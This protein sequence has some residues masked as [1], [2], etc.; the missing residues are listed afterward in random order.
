MQNNI[1]KLV[2]SSPELIMHDLVNGERIFN[3]GQVIRDQNSPLLEIY[4]KIITIIA[5]QKLADLTPQLGYGAGYLDVP[6]RLSQITIHDDPELWLYKTTLK[7]LLNQQ[8]L[9]LAIL[10]MQ[11]A[12]NKD[13]CD[14]SKLLDRISR[15]Y[16]DVDGWIDIDYSDPSSGWTAL[17][18]AANLGLDIIVKDLIQTYRASPDKLSYLDETPLLLASRN[19]HKSCYQYLNKY[20][21]DIRGYLS[22]QWT[23]ALYQSLNS[24]YPIIEPVNA[25]EQALL[26]V[27]NDNDTN[28]FSA[29]V[30]VNLILQQSS[31]CALLQVIPRI[32]VSLPDETRSIFTIFMLVI[33][34]GLFNNI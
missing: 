4:R 21:T 32:A 24:G 17:H 34:V 31:G 18:W 15:F 22:G 13:I 12:N 29:A 9:E 6:Y 25:I 30:V 27:D 23:P 28:V 16:E 26:T 1:T 11:R 5:P 19:S 3:Y 7:Q 33:A 8:I 10:S 2:S 14:Q 20:T